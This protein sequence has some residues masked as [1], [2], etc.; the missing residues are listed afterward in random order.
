MH[1]RHSRSALS[2][3]GTSPLLDDTLSS[4]D[5]E[6]SPSTA[7]QRACLLYID[8][9]KERGTDDAV[10]EFVELA[11]SVEVDIRQLYRVHCAR[12]SSRYFIGRG[13]ADEIRDYLAQEKI[14]LLIV[15]L[16]LSPAQ[17]R[18]LERLWCARVLGRSGLILDIFSR[19]ARSHEGKLQVELA[20]LNYLSTRLVRGWSHLERQ[21][22]GIGLRG[23]GEKQL[24][25]D[26]RLIGKRVARINKHLDRIRSQRCLGR[27]MRRKYDMPTIALVGYTNAG[28]TSLF[29]RLTRSKAYSADKLFA[30]LD[31]TMRRFRFKRGGGDRTMI[32]SDTVGFI[33]D[34]PDTLVAAFH[35]T[36]VEVREADLLLHVVDAT[37]PAHSGH[38]KEVDQVLHAIEATDILQ[39]TV[40]NKSDLTRCSPGIMRD[41]AGRPVSA[42]VSALTG[43]GIAELE[44]MLIELLAPPMRSYEARIP[45]SAGSLR[46]FIYDR[47][48]VVREEYLRAQGWR[49]Q[50]RLTDSAAGEILKRADQLGYALELSLSSGN[51]MGSGRC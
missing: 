6:H 13:K 31:P 14:P 41:G 17:E 34:L 49:L 8:L 35:A 15:N 29:N 33:R 9:G 1:D 36:L 22:G 7:G 45:V 43:A 37:V 23:P 50:L 5:R 19:R 38:R 20:Q 27:R 42:V 24:E 46:A 25:T 16:D 47:G 39:V 26:R 28:K 18:N 21:K 4:L 48:E 11:R 40:F 30:T 3:G 51:R 44:K 10:E 12:P 32:V 2:R